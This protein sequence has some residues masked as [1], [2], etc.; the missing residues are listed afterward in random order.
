MEV[1]DFVD[2]FVLAFV[3]NRVL[4]EQAML[5]RHVAKIAIVFFCHLNE[6]L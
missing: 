4:H 5:Y 2:I 3:C 1:A 6:K